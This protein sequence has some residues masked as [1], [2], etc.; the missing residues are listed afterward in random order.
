ML[1]VALNDPV[2]GSYNSAV[3]RASLPVAQ[4]PTTRGGRGP[5]RCGR[6]RQRHRGGADEGQLDSPSHASFPLL[7]RTLAGSHEALNPDW[8]AVEC[9]RVEIGQL[10]YR[11]DAEVVGQPVADAVVRRERVG[12]PPDRAVEPDQPRVDRLVE[13]R[14]PLHFL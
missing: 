4:R 2:D 11:V 10:R 9:A 8:S 5:G 12:P 6:H 14:E 3:S 1:P 13:R 7:E